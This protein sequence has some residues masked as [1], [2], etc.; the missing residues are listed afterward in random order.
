MGLETKCICDNFLL[1]KKHNKHLSW[2]QS[3]SAFYEADNLDYYAKRKL[4][5]QLKKNVVNKI[6]YDNLN[7]YSHFKVFKKHN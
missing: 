2:F 6:N 4:C 3:F 5:M 7:V 1:L